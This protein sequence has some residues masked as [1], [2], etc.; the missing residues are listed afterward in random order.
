VRTGPIPSDCFSLPHQTAI[1]SI[2][3][4]WA[5]VITVPDNG[6]V[7][8][9]AGGV[10]TSTLMIAQTG[11]S[12]SGTEWGEGDAAVAQGTLSGSLS[13]SNVMMTR[14]DTTPVVWQS[15]FAGTVSA[16]E[17]SM[18]GTGANDPAVDNGNNATYTWTASRL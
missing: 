10:Y 12:L 17:N 2:S 6:T 11:P 3:G 5:L 13:G 4:T 14:M 18:S 9:G 16:D 7:A 8:N 15:S 1:P